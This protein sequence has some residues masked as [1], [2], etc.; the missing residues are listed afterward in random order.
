MK[1]TMNSKIRTF[2]MVLL[3]SAGMVSC[4]LHEEP[5]RTSEGE[6]GVDPTQV[7]LD[8]NITLNLELP[9]TDR[10]IFEIPDTVMHRFI[11][12]A[13][14]SDRE[15]VQRQV[16]Y[17]KNTEA[18]SFA[19]PVSMRLHAAS[20]RIVVWSDYVRVSDPGAQL[21][22]NAESLTPVINNGSYRANT[23]AKDAFA[24]Y[25]DLDLH[26]YADRWNAR[27]EADIELLRPLGRYELVAQ[28]V[29]A[30][31]RRLAEGSVQGTTFS[32]RV[33]YAGYL[34]V[35]YNCYD[36]IR[37][38]SLNYM[39]YTTRFRVPADATE[40]SLAFDY[41]FVAPDEEL[42]VPVEIEIV[43]ENSVTVSRTQI[44]LPVQRNMNIIVKGRFLTSTADGGLSIDPGYDGD[45]TVDVGTLTPER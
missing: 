11:V 34:A 39:T 16:I 14:N 7:I 9:G 12:E 18:T 10:T 38:H 3:A 8:A 28:D 23:N 44:S 15:L 45:V 42:D 29:E 19:L 2:A 13:Y 4:T 5:Y 41:I 17:D 25:A 32:A 22:Y 20:Y 36:M 1:K 26:P 35:G 24:G 6:I 31:R 33:K 21:Y 30:F 43:N 27:I 37:K 40:L